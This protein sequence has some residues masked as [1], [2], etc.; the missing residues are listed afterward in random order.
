MSLPPAA[1][2]RVAAHPAI[3]GQEKVITSILQFLAKGGSTAAFTGAPLLAVCLPS[4]RINLQICGVICTEPGSRASRAFCVHN[5]SRLH[6]FSCIPPGLALPL[7]KIVQDIS[8]AELISGPLATR[9]LG[10]IIKTLHDARGKQ[11]L[12]CSCG[13]PACRVSPLL[14]SESVPSK[15]GPSVPFRRRS[16]GSGGSGFARGTGA[17]GFL[18]R[19]APLHCIYTFIFDGIRLLFWRRD[20]HG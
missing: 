2:A 6:Y 14:Y 12:R 5:L 20:E 11:F 10:V 15:K 17:R 13:A 18:A 1:A 16:A 19:F 7:A 9:G 8:I 3:A 4:A